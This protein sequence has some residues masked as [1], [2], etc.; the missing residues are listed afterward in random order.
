MGKQGLALDCQLAHRGPE[1]VTVTDKG[2]RPRY[3]PTG[4]DALHQGP[5]LKPGRERAELPPRC[6]VKCK[7]HI[8]LLIVGTLA[9][10]DLETGSLYVVMTVLELAM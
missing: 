5:F 4:G 7:G 10:C 3:L 6:T 2:P 9:I 8:Q 1:L